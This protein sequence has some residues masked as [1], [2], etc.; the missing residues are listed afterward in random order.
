MCRSTSQF[1]KDFT[2]ISHTQRFHGFQY[3]LL[4]WS[5]HNRSTELTLTRPRWVWGQSSAKQ[6]AAATFTHGQRL[7]AELTSGWPRASSLQPR[8]TNLCL[9]LH[10]NP[11]LTKLLADSRW[12]SQWSSTGALQVFSGLCRF[13][14]QF[15]SVVCLFT[16]F[17]SVKSNFF[18]LSSVTFQCK[19]HALILPFF[20]PSLAHFVFSKGQTLIT[21]LKVVRD[22]TALELF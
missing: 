17:L 7:L 14:P 11:A 8:L 6:W 4:C 15:F 22:F 9:D 5:L 18:P 12:G 10:Q 1:Y 19:I 16:L 21:T 20:F 3:V 13:T 2:E